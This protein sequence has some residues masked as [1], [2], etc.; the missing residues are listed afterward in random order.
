VIL[1]YATLPTIAVTKSAEPTSVAEPGDDVTFTVSVTNTSAETVTLTS[2]V[3]TVHGGLAGQGSCSL[4]QEVALGGLYGCAFTA[5]VS[6]NAGESETDLVVARAFDDA[7]NLAEASAS[8]TVTVTDVLPVIDVA[9]RADPASLDEPGGAVGFTVVVTN[10]SVETVTLTSLVDDPFGDLADLSN[11]VI[12]NSTCATGGAIDPNGGTYVCAFQVELSGAPGV[13]TDTVSATAED[14]E[15]NEAGDEARAVVTIADV[16]PSIAVTKVADPTQVLEPG[17][18]VTFTVRVTNTGQVERIT[19]ITLT[20]TVYGDLTLVPGSTC[21]PPQDLEPGAA[22]ECAFTAA[23]SGNAGDIETDVVTATASD[24]EG[25]LA[26]SDDD[27][28][29]TIEDVLPSIA[30]TKTADPTMIRSGDLVEFTIRVD[31]RSVEPVT[32]ANL[33]DTVFGD[34][35][36]E[37]G[38]PT[39]IA[40][41]GLFE[42][43]ISRTIGA[44]H[45]NTVTAT[46]V[47]DDG[48]AATDSAGASVDVI[49][50]AIRVIKEA[51]VASVRVGQTVTYTYRV[52]NAGDVP[53][54]DVRANDDRLGAI[55]LGRTALGVGEATTGTAVYVVAESDL[56]GPLINTVTVT[57]TPPV[58]PGVTNWDLRSVDVKPAIWNV[59]LPVAMRRAAGPAPDLVVESIQVG[60]GDV[61]VVVKNQGTAPVESADAFWVDLY[62]DPD[63]VPTGVNQTW[64]SLCSEGIAW[65]V[66][67]PAL[68]LEPGGTITLTLGGDYYWEDYSNFGGSLPVGTPIYVQ[69]DSADVGTAYGAVLE[70]HEIVGGPYNNIGGPVYPGLS[71]LGGG[72]VEV[73]R[74]PVGD[75]PPTSSRRLPPR[76]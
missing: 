17:G 54:T 3:D 60:G 15:G 67:P 14:D 41:G 23:V 55:A 22:Y 4:P 24:D 70:G 62:V 64:D 35:A 33:D 9:K 47:D 8:A 59:Y 26:S 19:V 12:L 44:D 39:E 73:R 43:A 68:P 16:L 1:T 37:C 75:P 5:T 6:G 50:P 58:G 21:A 40:V 49:G 63:P 56:P 34:L 72:P 52:E 36:A 31:N 18:T 45:T 65:G 66:E 53:L 74:F 11:P 76:P 25:N 69:V 13:Y 51:S 28:T 42:C 32:L 38:L 20:D 61:R 7:G 27:A 57:G 30:V 48:N 29:V 2:L 10:T 71:G 46:A